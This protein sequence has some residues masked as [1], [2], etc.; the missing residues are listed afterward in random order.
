MKMTATT[1]VPAGNADRRTSICSKFGID[2]SVNQL[3]AAGIIITFC[4][5]GVA[6]AAPTPTDF[7]GRWLSKKPE[8]TLDVSRCGNGWCGVEVTSGAACGSTILRL[9]VDK[10]G[11]DNT[12]LS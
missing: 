8:L 1:M 7:G 9:D 10:Q 12:R 2:A 5:A 11:N 4:V 6:I 3:V